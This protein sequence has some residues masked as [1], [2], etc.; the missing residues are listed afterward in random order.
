MTDA[1][2]VGVGNKLC[3]FIPSKS[4]DFLKYDGHRIIVFQVLSFHGS[5][6]SLGYYLSSPGMLAF[7]NW[8]SE[9]RMFGV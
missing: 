9:A 7:R 1:K 5:R 8:G 3:I 4:P 2:L 6:M